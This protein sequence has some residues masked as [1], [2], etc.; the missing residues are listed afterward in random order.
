MVPA[1]LQVAHPVVQAVQA[2]RVPPVEVSP[3]GQAV[4]AP[5]A[6]KKL[7]LQVWQVTVVPA[8]LQVAHPLAQAEQEVTAPPGEVVPS[9][10]A[11]QAPPWRKKLS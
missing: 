6:R 9:A 1:V 5:V 11:L 2:V 3:A 8:V 7:A 4:Q 10:Q